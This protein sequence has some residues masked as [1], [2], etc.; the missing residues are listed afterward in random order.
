MSDLKNRL[1][2]SSV[3]SDIFKLIKTRSKLSAT[4]ETPE[5]LLKPSERGLIVSPP[6][7]VMENG[8]FDVKDSNLSR[9]LIKS[10][11]FFWDRID[12]PSNNVFHIEQ[13]SP[14]IKFLES[15]GI[16]QKS[17]SRLSGPGNGG[18]IMLAS[19]LSA[20]HAL[21]EKN[22]GQWSMA[23]GEN[24]LSF[25]EQ[26][27][28]EN[29]G[30]IFEL[31]NTIPVPHEDVPFEDILE[32]K[33]RRFD[34]L[35]ALRHHLEEIYQKIASS[36]DQPLAEKTQFEKLDQAL[37]D[38]IKASRESGMNLSLSG[39]S[40][41]I[42]IGAGIN[43]TLLGLHKG[44]PLSGALLAGIA[45]TAGSISLKTGFGLKG[46]KKSSTPFDYAI[47]IQKEFK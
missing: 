23:S 31:H 11:L 36:P 10:A 47:G 39:L 33:L 1:M 34:E 42:D 29:R 43:A 5:N 26:E 14:E 28:V 12:A 9:A 35:M 4:V 40:S 24:S 46:K 27:K 6:I 22:P 16:L 3:G 13:G 38:H 21:E 2:S 17:F 41:S 45:T 19:N 37:S 15:E 25:P 18:E 8:S 30:F 44:L 7:Q 20:F 32:Y